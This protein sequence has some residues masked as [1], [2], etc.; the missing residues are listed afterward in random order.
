MDKEAS[1]IRSIRFT[2]SDLQAGSSLGQLL[3]AHPFPFP[4][5]TLLISNTDPYLNI[6][7]Y[8]GIN[9]KRYLSDCTILLEPK[10]LDDCNSPIY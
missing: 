3:N 1:T 4:T 5:H 10:F 7:A 9:A 8:V 2:L 6:L